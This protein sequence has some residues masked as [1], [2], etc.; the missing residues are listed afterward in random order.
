MTSP[1]EYE[2]VLERSPTGAF[3]VELD[4]GTIASFCGGYNLDDGNVLVYRVAGVVPFHVECVGFK[5]G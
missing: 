4:D 2:L 3:C 5:L 1:V